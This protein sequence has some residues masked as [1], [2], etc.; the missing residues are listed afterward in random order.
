M[1]CCDYNCDQGRECPARAAKPRNMPPAVPGSALEQA[2]YLRRT[3]QELGV[4]QSYVPR[5]GQCNDAAAGNADVNVVSGLDALCD[6]ILYWML[7]AFMVVCTVATTAGIAGF[8]Y[9]KFFQ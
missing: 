1:N 8:L 7:L 9:S 5:C 6:Q 3:C 4:C 2:P